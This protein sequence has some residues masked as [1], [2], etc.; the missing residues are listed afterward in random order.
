MFWLIVLSLLLLLMMM[1]L[2]ISLLLLPQGQLITGI[3]EYQRK[4]T[5]ACVTWLCFS[6]KLSTRRRRP[7]V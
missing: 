5:F 3:L 4:N 7:R 2:M 6:G 1:M